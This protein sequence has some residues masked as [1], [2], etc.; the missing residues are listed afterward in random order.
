MSRYTVTRN[1]LLHQAIVVKADSEAKAIALSRKAK[2]KDWSS[3]P[4]QR[5]KTNYEAAEFND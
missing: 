4:S 2:F 5:S 3:D 1:V